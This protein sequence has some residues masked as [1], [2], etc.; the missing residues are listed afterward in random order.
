MVKRKIGK[1]ELR[2]I[3]TE[4]IGD[5]LDEKQMNGIVDRVVGKIVGTRQPINEMAIAIKD[6]KNRIEGL[7]IQIVQN[8]C[9]CMYCKMFDPDNINFRH[10]AEELNAHISNIQTLKLKSGADKTEILKRLLI[11]DLEYDDVDVIFVLADGKF[12]LEDIS[13]DDKLKQV[14]EAFVEGVNRLIEVLAGNSVRSKQYIMET[15]FN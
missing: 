7:R 3:L 8:W 15:F 11:D 12:G 6:Y 1:E 5:A 10:W 14:C 9:L 4:A 13:D 2:K